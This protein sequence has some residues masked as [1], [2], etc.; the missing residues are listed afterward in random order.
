MS[1]DLRLDYFLE[2]GEVLGGQGS[3]VVL[4]EEFKFGLNVF[5]LG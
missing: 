3:V 4:E 1:E 2:V 5:D